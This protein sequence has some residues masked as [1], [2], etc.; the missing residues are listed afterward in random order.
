M[1]L[2]CVFYTQVPDKGWVRVTKVTQCKGDASV[3]NRKGKSI[4]AYELDVKCEWKGQVPLA[5]TTHPTHP[6]RLAV[7]GVTDMYVRVHCSDAW[8]SHVRLWRQVDYEDVSGEVLIPYISEDAA[9]DGYEVKLTVAEKDDDS[10]KKALRYLTKELP[11]IRER[12]QT[13]TDEIQK[14]DGKQKSS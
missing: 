11:T 9:S 4:I 14:Q 3:S 7:E 1:R 8:P 12:L 10:H 6:N 5:S 13:F 2:N